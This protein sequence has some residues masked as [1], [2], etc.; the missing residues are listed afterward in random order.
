DASPN[1]QGQNGLPL[2]NSWW[3]W[4]RSLTRWRLLSAFETTR[5]DHRF[6]QNGAFWGKLGDE[7]T[8]GPSEAPGLAGL[9]MMN[10]ALTDDLQRLLKKKVEN[11]QFPNEQA[12]VEEALRL[13]LIEKPDKGRPPT[14]SAT[15]PQKDNDEDAQPWRGVYALEFPEEVLFAKPIDICPEQLGEWRP[16][17]GTSERRVRNDDEL[18]LV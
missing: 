2:H 10:I 5:Q 13:F 11:G 17:G 6:C 9:T 18:P 4:A 16:Q 3:C 12:V 14:S 15:E 1:F 7:I 8:Q